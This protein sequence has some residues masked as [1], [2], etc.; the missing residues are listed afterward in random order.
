MSEEFGKIE[1]LLEKAKEY[2]NTRMAQIKLSVA[3]KISNVLSLVI[4]GLIAFLVFFIFLLFAS[5]GAAIAI[6]NMIGET[7]LGFLIM[8]AAW[9]LFGIMIWKG[10]NRLLRLPILNSIINSLSNDK[11]K[12]EEDKE[13]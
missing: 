7:W 6:G 10:R 2:F 5:I 3:E 1:S 13:Q 4:A 8:G 12:N 9:L 11:E